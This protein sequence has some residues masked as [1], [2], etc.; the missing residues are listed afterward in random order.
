LLPI[1]P[2]VINHQLHQ[3]A[4]ICSSLVI[5]GHQKIF[6]QPMPETTQGSGAVCA[7]WALQELVG[8]KKAWPDLMLQ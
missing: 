7:A 8:I 5:I 4:I 1:I 6:S 2:D 3:S